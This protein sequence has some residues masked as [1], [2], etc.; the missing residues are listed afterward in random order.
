MEGS[1]SNSLEHQAHKCPSCGHLDHGNFCSNCGAALSPRYTGTIMQFLEF[2]FRTHELKI[3]FST[4]L[5][6]LKSPVST[7][8]MYYQQGNARRA[9][10][11]LGWAASIYFLLALSRFWIIEDKGL[12]QSLL[13]TSQFVFTLSVSIPVIYWICSYVS[14]KKHSFHEFMIL[15]CYFVG[16]NLIFISIGSFVYSF[17]IWIGTLVLLVILVPLVWYTVILLKQFWQL[18]GFQVFIFLSLGSLAGSIVSLGI[19]FVAAQILD[20]QLI[21]PVVF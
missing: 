15:C 7:I 9:F 12:V 5:S 10:A 6:I 16:F 17:N 4:F 20:V 1:D 21:Q 11:F 14:E 19:L 18:S 13:F 2:F 3:F 8:K